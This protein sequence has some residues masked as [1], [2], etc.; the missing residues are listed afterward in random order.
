MITCSTLK[1]ET[2]REDKMGNLVH[3]EYLKDNTTSNNAYLKHDFRPASDNCGST[4][5]ISK[6]E[7]ASHPSNIKLEGNKIVLVKTIYSEK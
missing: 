6:H 7:I 1:L 4:R 2:A 3:S 5:L